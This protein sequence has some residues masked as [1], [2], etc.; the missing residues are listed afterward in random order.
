MK[1][2]VYILLILILFILLIINISF[3]GIDDDGDM[4]A[5]GSDKC[6]NSTNTSVDKDGCDCTQKTSTGCIYDPINS[7]WCCKTNQICNI[8][9]P[10]YDDLVWCMHDSDKDGIWK[11]IL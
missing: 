6:P 1:K 7:P 3:A 9:N 10:K 2:G 4:K 11:D 8:G 5:S